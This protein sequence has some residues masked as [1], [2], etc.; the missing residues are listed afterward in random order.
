LIFFVSSDIGR[1][2]KV[3]PLVKIFL[4]ETNLDVEIGDPP[5]QKGYEIPSQ[6]RL[7]TLIVLGSPW[8]YQS[9]VFVEFLRSIVLLRQCY[10]MKT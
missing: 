10:R 7:L 3:A 6:N 5:I 9:C 1:N 8:I 4:D 2:G